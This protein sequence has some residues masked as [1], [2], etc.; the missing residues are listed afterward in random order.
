MIDNWIPIDQAPTV[1]PLITG[2]HCD[3]LDFAEYGYPYYDCGES[4]E[5]FI[6]KARIL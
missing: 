3:T 5:L 1:D 2:I 4:E 6:E